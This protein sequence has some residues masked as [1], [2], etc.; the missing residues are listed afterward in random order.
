MNKQ[1]KQNPLTWF[2]V[3]EVGFLGSTKRAVN[4]MLLCALS[5]NL[6]QSQSFSYP[7]RTRFL[8]EATVNR[9]EE[10]GYTSMGFAGVTHFCKL[11]CVK[12]Y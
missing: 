10:M 12:G 11:A 2:L 4:N 6:A 9:L 3:A 8:L 5:A 7:T 1:E